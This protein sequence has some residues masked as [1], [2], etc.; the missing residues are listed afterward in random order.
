MGSLG[1]RFGRQLRALSSGEGRAELGGG[2]VKVSSKTRKKWGGGGEEGVVEIK[3]RDNPMRGG[4]LRA[5]GR[6]QAKDNRHLLRA[7]SGGF[8]KK[9]VLGGG[10]KMKTQQQQQAAED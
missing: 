4:D 8:H 6:E 3:M 9:P 10:E 1:K 7:A 2:E 5:G